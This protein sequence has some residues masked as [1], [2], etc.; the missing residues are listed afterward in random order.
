MLHLL[1]HVYFPLNAA[2]FA[3]KTCLWVEQIVSANARKLLCYWLFLELLIG[4]QVPDWCLVSS[5][6][7]HGPCCSGQLVSAPCMPCLNR[8]TGQL[9]A[10]VLQTQGVNLNPGIKNLG[11]QFVPVTT[12]TTGWFATNAGWRM[13]RYPTAAVVAVCATEA[14]VW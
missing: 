12:T 10:A 6:C 5:T 11:V 9:Q 3:R 4:H 7:E 13:G 14:S 1:N 8:T 2:T